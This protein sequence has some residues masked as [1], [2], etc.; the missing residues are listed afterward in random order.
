MK[1]FFD[2]DG[3][4]NEFLKKVMYVVFVNLLFILCSIPVVTAGASATAMYT[5]FFRFHQGDDPDILR[6]FFK[7]FKEN[8]KKSTTAWMIMLI[9][10]GSLS[11]NFRFVSDLNVAGKETVQIFINFILL[12][13]LVF[14][15]YLFPAM[16]YY[17]NTFL[18]YGQFVVRLAIAKFPQTIAILMLHFVLVGIILFTAQYSSFGVFLF[19]CCGFSLPA[20]F[21][22][23]IL[24]KKYMQFEEKQY[25]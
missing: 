5:V 24:L 19:I 17:E 18:G 21:S 14:W 10:A 16:C 20:Y 13:W 4:L 22:G 11:V 15:V 12:L 6:T 9:I 2:Y 7:S 3:M 23:G 8:F 25:E 1:G